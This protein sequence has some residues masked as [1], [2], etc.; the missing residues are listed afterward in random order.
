KHRLTDLQCAYMGDERADLPILRRAGFSATVNETQDYIK[1][2]CH[3]V[4]TQ[5]AGDGA[6]R[7]FIEIILAH[8]SSSG[9]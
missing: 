4:A 8:R 3:F 2:D 9:R 6:A 7:E 1:Q 5:P